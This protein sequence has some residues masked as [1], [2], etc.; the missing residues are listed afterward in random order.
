MKNDLE[1]IDKF[2][3]EGLKSY[4]EKPSEKLKRRVGRGL[5][6]SGLFSGF[7][8][9][10]NLNSYFFEIFDVLLICAV[11]CFF[12]KCSENSKLPVS[13]LISQ[14]KKAKT[15]NNDASD[16]IEVKQQKQSNELPKQREGSQVKETFSFIN[17]KPANS[18]DSSNTNIISK[19]KESKTNNNKTNDNKI[20][21]TPELTLNNEVKEPVDA[22][23]ETKNK[24]EIK[25]QTELKTENKIITEN[26][27]IKIDE[28][29]SVAIKTEVK[30]DSTI[31]D[32]NKS[33]DTTNN[34]KSN[35]TNKDS[36]ITETKPEETKPV[37]KTNGRNN[38]S[39]E[40]T[41]S[42]IIHIDKFSTNDNNLINYIANR[43][44]SE[45]PQL[46]YSFGAEAKY[47]INN[48]YLK[49]GIAFFQLNKKS[50]YSYS[51]TTVTIDS[52]AVVDSLHYIGWDSLAGK[53][54]YDTVWKNIKTI[55][56]KTNTI[57][58]KYKNSLKYIEIPLLIGYEFGKNKFTFRVTAGT[59]IAFYLSSKGKVISTDLKE[60]VDFNKSNFP[61]RNN[62]FNFICRVGLCYKLNDKISIVAEPSF[63]C[64][65]SSIF[66]DSFGIKQKIYS[67]GLNAGVG[68]KL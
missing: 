30:K 67:F 47:N 44:T 58:E 15:N 45:K 66:K 12:N 1:N 57:Y 5:F 10:K 63:K 18:V 28:R 2:F 25:G 64:P 31:T 43:K 19:T 56:D 37:Q 22:D 48:F 53:P 54:I 33:V 38:F 16:I 65:F 21:K 46:S 27:N 60:V 32:I 7:S 51:K 34:V 14:T 26:N 9:L 23:S 6:L 35:K 8:F 3:K 13:N 40:L 62:F 50:N 61:F 17:E 11:F 68:F 4:K 55:T 41:A 52:V 39:L 49:S 42:P 36:T 29:K 59:S 20:N 24:T